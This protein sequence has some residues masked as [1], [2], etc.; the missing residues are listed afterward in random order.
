[1]SQSFFH[2]IF[3]VLDVVSLCRCA[4]V[5]KVRMCVGVVVGV[6]CGILSSV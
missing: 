3:S 6:V 2:R 1:M 5:S 4:Q